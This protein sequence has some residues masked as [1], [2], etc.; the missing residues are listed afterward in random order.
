LAYEAS[1]PPN[2]RET[3][4]TEAAETLVAWVHGRRVSWA[5]D[6]G[7]RAHRPS[8]RTA[9]RT[10]S[11]SQG[12]AVPAPVLPA[13]PAPSTIAL[14]VSDWQPAVHVLQPPS[15]SEWQPTVPAWKPAEPFSYPPAIETERAPVVESPPRVAGTRAATATASS[16]APLLRGSLRVGAAAAGIAVVAGAVWLARPYWRP[17]T[18]KVTIGTAIIESVPPGADVLVDGVAAGSAPFRAELQAGHHVIE[19]RRRKDVRKVDI[20]VRA[21]RATSAR[22]DWNA[23]AT[24]RLVV[25][26]DPAGSRVLV[27]GKDRGITPLTLDDVPVGSHAVLIQN[28]QGSVQRT[29]VIAT[30]RPVQL[31]ESIY[32]GL[33]K[34]FA[35]FDL[36]ITESGRALRLDDQNQVMMPSGRHE[37][38]IENR[39]FGYR[40]VTRVQVE[41][42][43][44]TSLSVVPPPSALSVTSTIPATVEVDGEPAGGTPLND[45]AIKLG[46]HEIVVRS[47]AGDRRFTKAVTV[48]PV[49][50]DV[51]FSKP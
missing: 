36:Q 51:D 25:N 28:D 2:D 40:Q 13:A 38:Q 21:G 26:S 15:A 6:S 1:N 35:P 48:A 46:T 19:F 39:A 10:T 17:L 27:D 41:P 23:S 45:A 12:D 3:H 11:P 47:A 29:V 34:V 7:I 22:V 24:G 14:S 5:G 37:L 30:D 33:L 9:A 43:V 32:A 42:G 4:L 20:D 50:I 16:G 8:R 49:R 44:T 31:S 18:T